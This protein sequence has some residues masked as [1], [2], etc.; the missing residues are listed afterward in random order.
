MRILVSA[1]ELIDRGLWDDFCEK[2]GY[3][4]WAVNE[5][6][7]DSDE[8][9]SFS[10]QEA[11][12]LGLIPHSDTYRDYDYQPLP[13]IVEEEPDLVAYLTKIGAD[14]EVIALAAK[15]VARRQK[16]EQGL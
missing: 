14:E 10:R 4:V 2:R 8:E 7:M 16:R 9:F 12:D 3:N 5:G 6:L 1:S 11:M 13:T 15:V